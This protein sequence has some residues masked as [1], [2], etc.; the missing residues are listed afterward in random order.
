MTCATRRAP[1]LHVACLIFVLR[2]RFEYYLQE[3]AEG[4]EGR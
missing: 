2:D 3:S 4:D 1:R